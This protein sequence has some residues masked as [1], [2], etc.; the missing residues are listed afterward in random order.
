VK[1]AKTHGGRRHGLRSVDDRGTP[2]AGHT[3]TAVPGSTQVDDI[4]GVRWTVDARRAVA[5]L[6]TVLLGRPVDQPRHG[7]TVI[8]TVDLAEYLRR[9]R[10]DDAALRLL[11]LS[12]VAL[13]RVRGRLGHRHAS[14]RGGRRHGLA[15]EGPAPR[16]LVSLEPHHIA[17]LA[18]ESARTGRARAEL[19]RDALDA[20]ITTGG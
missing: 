6:P 15:P 17:W 13:R 2:P 1:A 18:E 4:D 9:H 8:V 14:G 19:I 20:L 10:D 5:G 16:I 7:M 12:A 11:P 3:Q